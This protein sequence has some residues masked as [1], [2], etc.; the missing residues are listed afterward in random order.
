MLL[1]ALADETNLAALS[2]HDRAPNHYI[3][4]YNSANPVIFL[5]QVARYWLQLV[6]P[7]FLLS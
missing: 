2:N 6:F 5:M 4:G 7:N 3:N 1:H